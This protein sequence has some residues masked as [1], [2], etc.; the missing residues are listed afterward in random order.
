M[1]YFAVPLVDVVLEWE[2]EGGYVSLLEF[3]CVWVERFVFWI[4]Y[5]TSRVHFLH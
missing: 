5:F 2:E 3:W 1:L 4:E